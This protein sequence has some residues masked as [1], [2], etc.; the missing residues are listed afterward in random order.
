MKE[1]D[2]KCDDIIE[3]SIDFSFWKPEGEKAFLRKAFDIPKGMKVGIWVGKFIQQKWGCM[4][5]II[6]KRQDIFWILC[7]SDPVN[8]NPRMKNVK[9][10]NTLNPDQMRT[11]Y[12][13]SDF[14]ICTSW[15]EAFNL[16]ALEAAACNIPIIMP[17]VGF[18]YGWWDEKI[19]ERVCPDASPDE[20]NQMDYSIAIDTVLEGDTYNP[21]EKSIERF[22]FGSFIERWRN[23]IESVKNEVE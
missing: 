21:R 1:I 4:T 3:H 12:T 14:Y 5:E 7:F 8:Y 11:L 9:I 23:I 16:S 6:R 20:L 22:P 15:C 19:G 2:I 17:S 13:L 10:F 18:A